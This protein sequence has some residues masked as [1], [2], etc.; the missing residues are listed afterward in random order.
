[1]AAETFW[2]SREQAQKL[3]DEAASLRKRVEPLFDAE[4]KLEDLQVMVELCEAE[5]AE[6]QSKHLR[7][8]QPDVAKFTEQLDALELRV[9][10]RG[11]HDQRNCILNINADA[12]G[13]E[14][15]D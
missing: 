2:N 8:L 13:T 12:G 1:M 4:K 3:I 7:E 11:P 14:A 9:L 10:L 5:P 15:C 6:A